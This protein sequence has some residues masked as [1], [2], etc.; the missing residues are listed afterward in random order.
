VRGA[1]ADRIARVSAIVAAQ[2]G[3]RVSVEGYSDGAAKQALSENRASAVRR[4]L[5]NNG[6]PAAVVS[7]RGLGDSRPV[8]PPGQDENSRV[9]IVI[10]GDPI[11]TVPFWDHTYSL[12]R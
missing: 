6:L 1:A 10:S 5:T 4:V 12:T 9:E 11:G 8:G 2:P 3:L 7:S